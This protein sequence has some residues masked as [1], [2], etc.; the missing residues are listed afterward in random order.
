MT[1]RGC[2]AVQALSF[3][4]RVDC[5]AADLEETR[6]GS[7]SARTQHTKEKKQQQ[8]Q[9]QKHLGPRHRDMQL[10]IGDEKVGVETAVQAKQLQPFGVTMT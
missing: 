4:Q 8:Q 6:K 7:I 3:F 1:A 2:G 9:H 5:D 10:L